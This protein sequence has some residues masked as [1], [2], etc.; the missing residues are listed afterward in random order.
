MS[1]QLKPKLQWNADTFFQ[2]SSENGIYSFSSWLTECGQVQLEG[3][4]LVWKRASVLSLMAGNQLQLTSV[5]SKSSCVI[6]INLCYQNMSFGGNVVRNVLQGTSWCVEIRSSLRQREFP[7][8]QYFLASY[9]LLRG[10]P[11]ASEVEVEVKTSIRLLVVQNC[12]HLPSGLFWFYLEWINLQFILGAGGRWCCFWRFPTTVPVSRARFPPSVSTLLPLHSSVQLKQTQRFCVICSCKTLTKTVTSFLLP[13]LLGPIN[14][15]SAACCNHHSRLLS[16]AVQSSRTFSIQT[17]CPWNAFL[18][19][20]DL[21]FN[22]IRFMFWMMSNTPLCVAVLYFWSI[23]Q[24]RGKLSHE[25]AK[26]D[27]EKFGLFFFSD[28]IKSNP[29]WSVC[30]WR[31]GS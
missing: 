31:W 10:K 25:A 29:P 28:L 24:P 23:L 5:R 4:V 8:R 16:W 2:L 14:L 3:G 22:S 30:V 19:S 1:Q 11:E 18:R 12:N 9:L 26:T 15:L 6:T 7:A 17:V 20:R 27:F 21:W 13:S